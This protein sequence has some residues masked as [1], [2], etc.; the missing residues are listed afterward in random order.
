V[1]LFRP[2]SLAPAA[3]LLLVA[4]AAPDRPHGGFIGRVG[5]DLAAAPAGLWDDTVATFGDGGNLLILGAAALSEAVLINTGIE[6]R[7]ADFWEQEDHLTDDASDALSFLGTGVFLLPAGAA[8]YA[9]GTWTGDERARGAGQDVLSALSI[10]G[11]TTLGLKE[12]FPDDRPNGRSGGYPSGHSSMAMAAAAALA[13]SYGSAV[14]VPAYAL[15][16]AVGVQRMDRR[17]HDLDDVSF[18]WVLGWVV[19]KSVSQDHAP[20][21][22]GMELVPYVD[23]WGNA[24]IGL[25]RR[26]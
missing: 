8:L 22:L 21:L 3:A 18:G 10:T 12:L 20:E 1:S 16:V 2:P 9:T 4:C 17:W 7:V 19:G 5:E 25:A 11:V 13:E 23:P 26:F 14:D 6:D 24:G 15:A